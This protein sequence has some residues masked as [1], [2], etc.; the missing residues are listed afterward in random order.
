ML[1]TSLLSFFPNPLLA[2]GVFPFDGAGEVVCSLSITSSLS[3]VVVVGGGGVQVRDVVRHVP[4][5]IQIS[6]LRLVRV[7]HFPPS[8]RV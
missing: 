1:Y 6:V 4:S 8:S 2:F 3:V 7:C 5:V